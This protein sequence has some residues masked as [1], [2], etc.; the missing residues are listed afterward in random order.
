MGCVS[1]P[2]DFPAGT[3]SPGGG[4]VPTPVP[5]DNSG[6]CPDGYILSSDGTTCVPIAGTPQP[7]QPPSQPTPPPSQPVPPPASSGGSTASPTHNMR[8]S[9]AASLWNDGEGKWVYNGVNAIPVGT[10]GTV[11]GAGYV[12]GGILCYPLT[13]LAP[14]RPIPNGWTGQGY[15]IPK[16]DVTLTS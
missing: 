5:P 14:C 1:N 11:R 4:S 8:V 12:K 15:Y 2:Q 9:H 16:A 10:T 3:N 6:A 13:H 7:A